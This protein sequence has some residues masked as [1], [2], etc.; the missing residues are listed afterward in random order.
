MLNT[1]IKWL[2]FV[3]VIVWVLVAGCC[4]AGCS[5]PV[6]N[7]YYNEPVKP[8]P[9]ALTTPN[10][11]SKFYNGF[12]QYLAE[13]NCLLESECV[14]ELRPYCVVDDEGVQKCRDA[15]RDSDIEIDG[16]CVAKNNKCIQAYNDLWWVTHDLLPEVCQSYGTCK[17][18]IRAKYYHD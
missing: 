5:N 3:N 9:F 1:I 2:A 8:K 14:E 17:A 13:N 15:V 7:G 10:Y 11:D 12:Q 6:D 4:C 18:E 16:H